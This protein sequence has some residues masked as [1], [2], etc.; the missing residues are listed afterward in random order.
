M[1]LA[2][3]ASVFLASLAMAVLITNVWWRLTPS[4]DLD[5][6]VYDQSVSDDGFREHAILDQ[7]L[8]YHRVPFTLGEDHIG[9]APGG[10]PF[11][12]W[13]T[14]QPDAIVLADTYGVY[15][16]S[17]GEIDDLGS[18]RVSGVIDVEQAD[19]LERW[20][21]AGTPAYGEFS[22]FTAPT[23]L[24]AAAVLERSFSLE[25]TGW[26]FTAV[27]EL[28]DVSPTLRSLGPTPWPYEG[29]GFL[30]VHVTTANGGEGSRELIVLTEDQLTAPFPDVIGAAPG[31]I[32]GD[33][34][35]PR[36]FSWVQPIGDAEVTAWF[37]L[38][39]TEE[40]AEVLAEAGIP[41]SL[42]AVITT[43]RTLYFAGD[44]LDDE[45]PF[46]LRRLKGGSVLTRL[47]TGDEFRFVYTVLEPAIGWLVERS[48]EL[49]PERATGS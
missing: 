30:A 49:A 14:E 48:L 10:E 29:R 1:A 11:G 25:S 46:R 22:L 8:M 31:G 5:L 41:T 7:L 32:S 35:F 2:K 23:P 47:V 27:E 20:I 17:F 38:Q 36:W 19:D 44:G 15:V 42:P 21:G 37:D 24:D 40:G 33:A 13:P 28:A 45:T 39:V 4:R 43:D 26:V 18:R 6:L 3:V 9:A 16:D 12:D 34:P